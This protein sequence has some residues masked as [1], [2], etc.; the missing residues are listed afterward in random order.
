[1]TLLGCFVTPHPPII[2]PEVGGGS[3]SQV[4]AT[5]AAM[6]DLGKKA[7]LLAPHTIV[8]MS[9]H[10][11]LTSGHMG[12]SMG[13][14]YRG[15]LASF[16]APQVRIEAEGDQVLAESIARRAASH[17]V[18]TTLTASLDEVVDVDHGAMVPL[19]Y[20]FGGLAAP[21]ELVLLSFSY[22]DLT[23]HVR[24][25]VAI[26]EALLESPSPVLYVASGDLSHRLTPQAPA[27]YD[28]RGAMFDR[29]VVA[30]FSSGDWEGLL[31][32]DPGIVGAAGE[33]GYRSLAVLA[34]LVSAANA[35]GL[36][37]RNR[38]LSYEGPFGVGYL[39]GEVEVMAP[40]DPGVENHD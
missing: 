13:R 6:T 5:V 36:Q 8:M 9:P 26:G 14:G 12:I 23:E 35:A 11:H 21:S 25:G 28:P 7:G 38:L 10:G 19:S 18:P 1:V 29:A 27:G 40:S 16:R 22:L 20:L 37:T 31:S 15:S 30:S 17:G 3:L 32:I 4:K 2:V 33:C 24:F 39:V 34:G